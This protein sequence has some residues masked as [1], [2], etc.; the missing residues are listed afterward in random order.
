MSHVSANKKKLLARIRR[1][2]GQVEALEK[3]L[4]ADPDCMAVL[5]QI[6]AVRGAAQGLMMEV[7]DGH[8]Q[9]HLAEEPD[10]KKREEEIAGISTML[11][12][13]FK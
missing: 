13:Y 6:A 3:S 2:R 4:D 5:T 12:S 11:R 8:L 9:E 1:I 7:L 10:R